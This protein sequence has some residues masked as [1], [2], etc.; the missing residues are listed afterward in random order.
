M[1]IRIYIHSVIHVSRRLD[2]F[3]G[4][5]ASSNIAIYT[6]TTSTVVDM[7]NIRLTDGMADSGTTG[8][9]MELGRVASKYTVVAAVICKKGGP[10]EY[11]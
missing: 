5:K 7:Q 10:E 8:R 11:E 2:S 6:Y 3:A 9:L 4:S 1:R